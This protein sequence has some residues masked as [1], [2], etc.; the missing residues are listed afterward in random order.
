MAYSST[1]RAWLWSTLTPRLRFMAS[2][3]AQQIAPAGACH[4]N[5]GVTPLHNAS[6]PS[7]CAICFMRPKELK[8]VL[9]PEQAH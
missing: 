3:T 8:A 7:C 1:S 6:T 9:H 4:R 2:Y 5:L